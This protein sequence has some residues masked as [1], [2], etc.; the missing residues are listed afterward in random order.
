M[1]AQT[2]TLQ[3]KERCEKRFLSAMG[4]MTPPMEAPVVVRP[5]ATPRLRMK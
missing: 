3:P 2:R 5:R 1:K 4:Q